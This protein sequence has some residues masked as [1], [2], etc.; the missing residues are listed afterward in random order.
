MI[1]DVSYLS[2]NR[3]ELESQSISVCKIHPKSRHFS[4]QQGVNTTSEGKGEVSRV[5]VSIINLVTLVNG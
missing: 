1:F 5:W 2:Q 4:A 3:V